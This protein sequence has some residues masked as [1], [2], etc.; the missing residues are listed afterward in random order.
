MPT[1]PHT[2]TL[3]PTKYSGCCGH[4]VLSAGVC[5]NSTHAHRVGV[6][7]TLQTPAG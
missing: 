5:S 1:L 3:R 4:M 7:N 6:D 2:N